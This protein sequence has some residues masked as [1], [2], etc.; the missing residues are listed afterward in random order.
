MST[1]FGLRVL[2]PARHLHI[3]HLHCVRN[4][5]L[6]VT[7]TLERVVLSLISYNFSGA[8]CN[9]FAEKHRIAFAAFSIASEFG[10]QR[11]SS[12]FSFL[13]PN[14]PA[15]FPAQFPARFPARPKPNSAH[16]GLWR[17]QDK[18]EECVKFLIL[19]DRFSA[20]FVLPKYVGILSSRRV[21]LEF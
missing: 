4:V 13:R 3:L 18:R 5:V 15:H 7:F 6:A 11:F 9:I 2:L 1:F 10:I 21:R 17:D 14:H 19:T 20:T 12:E 16:F 8:R